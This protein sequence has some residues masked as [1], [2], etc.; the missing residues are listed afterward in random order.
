[1][2]QRLDEIVVI[3]LEATCWRGPPPP[4][5]VKEI[6]EIGVCVLE[7]ATLS[8]RGKASLLCRP[9][10]SQVSP[11]CTELTTLTPEMVAG[12]VPFAEAC[13]DLAARL[14]TP[15]RTF[16]SWGD[17]DRRLLEEQCAREGVKYPLSPTHLNVKNLFALVHGLPEEIGMMQALRAAGVPHEGT[18]H[19]GHDDAWNIAALLAGLIAPARARRA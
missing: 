10:R 17:F 7:T 11:F 6:I 1:M 14:G 5:Q 9:S 12:G 19:R 18:H 13:A 15:E 8:R 4:G 16:A 3:D 2:A